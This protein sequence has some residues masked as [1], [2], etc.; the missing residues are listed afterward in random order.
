[1]FDWVTEVWIVESVII[2]LIALLFAVV[3]CKI[4]RCCSGDD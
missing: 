3:A 1:M 4:I 2:I